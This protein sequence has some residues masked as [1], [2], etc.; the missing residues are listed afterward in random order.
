MNKKNTFIDS[1]EWAS[2]VD[3]IKGIMASDSVIETLIDFERVLDEADLYAFKNWGMGELVDGPVVKRYDVICTFMWPKT[4][5]P[6]PRGA[7]RLLPLGCKVGYKK[8]T[9]KSPIKVESPNDF[10]SGSH[11]PK[12]VE[13]EIWLVRIAI[14]KNLMNDIREGSVDVADQSIDLAD[15]DDAYQEDYDTADVK[16]TEDDQAAQQLQAPM[17]MPPGPG[18]GI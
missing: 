9:M 16:S 5:M 8:T 13:R 11:Y 10:Q 14:P 18:L 1:P 4:L 7:K 12:L 3:N 15:L 17:G 2:I 6:D